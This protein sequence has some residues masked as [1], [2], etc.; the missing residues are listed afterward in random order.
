MKNSC[1]QINKAVLIFIIPLLFVFCAA[2]VIRAS[3]VKDI[4]AKRDAGKTIYV[5]Y[6]Q[7]WETVY[8]AAKFVMHNSKNMDIGIR[9]PEFLLDH[10]I[11]NKAIYTSRNSLAGYGVFFEPLGANR[12]KVD[13]VATGIRNDEIV[14]FLFIEE[15]SYLLDHGKQAYRQYTLKLQEKRQKQNFPVHLR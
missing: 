13:C 3:V 7:D 14:L 9:Y 11:E 8:A 1:N 2:T 5:V 12:T 15:L 6:E 10:A 4:D